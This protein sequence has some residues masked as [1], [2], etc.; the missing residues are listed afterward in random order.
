L[1]ATNNGGITITNTLFEGNES[2][3][4][5]GA[6]YSL[7][8][9]HDYIGCLFRDNIS[10]ATGSYGGGA[11]QVDQNTHNFYN[12]TFTGNQANNGYGGALRPYTWNTVN[13]YNCTFSNNSASSGGGIYNTAT[14]NIYNTIIS[15]NTGNDYAGTQPSTIKNTLCKDG[16]IDYA[17]FKTDPN[18]SGLDDWG[19]DT[20]T[21][22]LLSGSVCIDA[23]DKATAYATDARGVSRDEAP[24]IGAYEENSM[25]TTTWNGS[26]WDN[27]SPDAA[28]RAVIDG[29]LTTTGDLSANYLVVTAGNTLT[30]SD[31]NTFDINKNT[32]VY[33][34]LTIE[35]TYNFGGSWIAGSTT[36]AVNLT[37]SNQTI[38]GDN[39]FGGFH[40]TVTSS[41]VLYFEVNKTQ[42][43]GD[44]TLSGAS[45]D[46][47]SLKSTLEG[48][49]F[50]LT[51]SGT[52]NINWL[53]V[54]DANN[55][56]SDIHAPNSIDDGN[57]VGWTFDAPA[58]T[59]W[60]SPGAWDNGA[61][62]V[63]KDAI[64]N[65]LYD[66]STSIECKSLKVNSSVVL[67]I[68]SDNTVT[69]DEGV[70]NDG[71]I[72]LKSDASGDASLLINGSISGSGTYNVER[73]LTGSQWHLVTSPITSG[74]AGV[75]EDIWLRPYDES[76][77]TFGEYI[78][79]T[80]T[81][82]PTGQGFSVWADVNETRTFTGTI[83]H[84]VIGPLGAQLTGAAGPDAGWNLMGN[85]YPSAIDWSAA[86]GWTKND[87]ADAVYVWNN[88]QYATYIDG[89]GSNGGSQYIAPGQGFFVQAT[90]AGAS[91]SM[92][93]DVRVHNGVNFMKNTESDPENTI[94]IT[95]SA[96]GYE[97]ENVIV[98]REANA[99]AFDP[100][101]D[102]YKLPGSS[103]AP[104]MHI[105]K[106]DFSRLAIASF[107]QMH[108]I[109]D[110]TL[111]VDY[112]QEGTHSLSWSHNCTAENT[113]GLL[114][115]QTGDIIEAGSNYTFT[116]AHTDMEDRFVFSAD[117][118]SLEENINALA[119]WEYNNTVF[120]NSND[121]R[122]NQISVYSLQGVEVYS[123]TGNQ[124]DLNHLAPAMYLVK[125]KSGNKVKNEKIVIK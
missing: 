118:T 43:T 98:I 112:A 114:D 71:T 74:T 1:Y 35:G 73:Y 120:V 119:V 113:P 122:E 14:L 51:S 68:A 11:I 3:N 29:D 19:G 48:T 46:F 96:D 69:V 86:S 123:N 6:I 72:T 106:D 116:A 31:G 49:K 52:R 61:P 79:P 17:L 58:I 124:F 50:N 91:L 111:H 40:K 99:N 64:I 105:E 13:L 108:D 89:T 92:D 70:I 77:N 117:L 33:G 82:M 81:P 93:N 39:S 78:T 15:D 97:D 25:T 42:T 16:S 76:T 56:G 30:V 27:G 38:A 12:C 32:G 20:H 5:G 102:A 34:T 28:K 67:E 103:D 121:N 24:D 18:L 44:L 57:N 95:V 63:T 41:D 45:L 7:Q 4:S 109:D 85:P 107:P 47:L 55:S 10:N 37:G 23:A 26:A 22:K 80:T 125:V 9:S 115:Q 53:I 87:L 54:K 66:L 60:E 94:R 110:K 75:F 65:Y 8:G 101:A 83:N 104:Q 36:G 21:F 84:G 88:D 59:T 2:A 100:Q 62:D 90:G